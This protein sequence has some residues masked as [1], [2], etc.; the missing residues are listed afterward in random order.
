MMNILLIAPPFSGHL[1]PMLGLG[2]YLKQYYKVKVLSTYSAKQAIESAGLSGVYCL[3]GKEELILEI[4]HPQK[5]IGNN[6]LGLYQQLKKHVSLLAE[7]QHE[8]A[9]HLQSQPPS[10]LIADFTQ[11]M[12]GPLAKQFGIPW[13][14]LSPSPCTYQAKSGPVSYMGGTMPSTGVLGKVRDQLHDSLVRSF[15]GLMFLVFRKLFKSLGFESVYRKGGA[16]AIYSDQKYFALGS[17]EFEFERE[18]YPGYTQIGPILYTPPYEGPKPVFEKNKRYVLITLGTHLPH[19][20][21]K[22][23]AQVRLTA[24]AYPELTFHFTYGDYHGDHQSKEGNVEVYSF[25][26][27]HDLLMEYALVVHHGGAGITYACI[28]DGIKAICYPLDY[29][30]FDFAA[31]IVHAGIGLRLKKLKHLTSL[32]GKAINSQPMQKR[33]AKLQTASKNY[34]PYESI[35]AEIEKLPNA[36]RI[37]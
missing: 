16:E 3:K 28:K 34:D 20:K 8:I 11:I 37:N 35:R 30:Q 32:V 13:F 1:N 6:P 5:E 23:L 14:T 7:L 31:R 24:K 17:N 4:I 10:L 25:I 21:E 9:Q 36:S 26:S 15:K 33:V 18:G 2:V 27:Y 22:V 12:T 29:D 19:Q